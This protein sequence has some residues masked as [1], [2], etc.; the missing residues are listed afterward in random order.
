MELMLQV[1]CHMNMG[2]NTSINEVRKKTF[3]SKAGGQAQFFLA[4][5]VSKVFCVLP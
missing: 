2:S 4:K 5:S 1:K 3:E